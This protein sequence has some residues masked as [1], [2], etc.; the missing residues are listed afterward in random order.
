MTTLLYGSIIQIRSTESI[1][2]N[3]LFYVERLEEDELVLKSND[4]NVLILP[5]EDGSLGE[6]IIEIIV[7][8][9]PLHNYSIQNKLFKSQWVEV[10][11]EDQTVKGQIVNADDVIEILLQDKTIYIPVDRG[12]PCI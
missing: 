6:S 9:K 11:F 7:L 4:G 10:T 8:Y 12:L 1:Y 2:E 5:I 3:K